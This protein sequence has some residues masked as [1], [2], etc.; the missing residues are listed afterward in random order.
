MAWPLSKNL[1]QL[2]MSGNSVKARR[3]SQKSLGLY[4]ARVTD[5]SDHQAFFLEYKNG[6]F[7][8]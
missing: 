6:S 2:L 8:F 1:D 7:L 4:Y 3:F 5:Y